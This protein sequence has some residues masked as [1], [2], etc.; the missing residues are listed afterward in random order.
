VNVVWASTVDSSRFAHSGS[1]I[2]IGTTIKVKGICCRL[3]FTVC[4]CTKLHICFQ[5]D[6]D[7]GGDQIFLP[8]VF[9]FD[10][11]SANCTRC[12][13][14]KEFQLHRSFSSKCAA[15][16]RRVNGNFTRINVEG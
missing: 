4:R 13:E 14:N 11:C 9:E 16:H 1:H 2:G 7:R 15:D 10:H 12:K 6:M 8:A 3:Q 5:S